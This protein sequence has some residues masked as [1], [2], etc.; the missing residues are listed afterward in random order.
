MSHEPRNA[1]CQGTRI[2]ITKNMRAMERR[3]AVGRREVETSLGLDFGNH[4]RMIDAKRRMPYLLNIFRMRWV[5]HSS[6]NKNHHI[7]QTSPKAMGSRIIASGA[8]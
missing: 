7:A 1:T 8:K 3:A 4:E 5:G 6:T 2:K